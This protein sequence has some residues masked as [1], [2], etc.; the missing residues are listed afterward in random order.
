MTIRTDVRTPD[1]V[2][3]IRTDLA[4]GGA[5]SLMA[6]MAKRFVA[7][8]RRVAVISLEGDGP[9][10]AAL[11]A[12]GVRVACLVRRWRWDLR[13]AIQ[14]RRL[15][16]EFGASCIICF[17]LY[18]HLFLRLGGCR[19]PDSPVL[20]SIHSTDLASPYRESQHWV[21]ARLLS[22]QTRIIA[23]CDAQVDYWSA[24]YSIPRERFRRIYNGVD[25]AAYRPDAGCHVGAESRERLGIPRV[26]F[27][28]VLVAALHEHKR[29]EVAIAALAMLRARRPELDAH[30]L[31]VGADPAGRAAGLAAILFI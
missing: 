15:L 31:A 5:Q 12:N 24:K 20:L 22:R 19:Q 16:H 7:A 26:A 6:A 13:P 4:V 25:T 17:G 3:L 8:G 2:V 1:G 10:S 30:L 23:V 18:E 27:V 21:Y 29:H 9:H 14:L 28:I 11:R